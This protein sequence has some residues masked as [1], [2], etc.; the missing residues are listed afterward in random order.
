MSTIGKAILHAPGAR[1]RQWAADWA[2]TARQQVR[3][4]LAIPA[5]IAWDVARIA[6]LV[7]VGVIMHAWNLFGYPRYQGDEGVYMASAWSLLHGNITPY[8][9][10]YGHPPLGWA[11]IALWCQMTGGF[12][13]FGTSV[14]TGRVF[15]VVC[16]AVSAIF[17]YLIALRVTR[18]WH[19]ATIATALFSYSPLSITFQ[20]EVLLDN[21]AIMWMLIAVYLLVISDSRMRY[22]LASAALFG[23]STLTKETMIVL[24][25][26]FAVGVW[27]GVTPFQR[28]YV[29]LVF[30]YATLGIVSIFVLVSLLKNEF[31]PTGTL[32][33][34]QAPHVSMIATFQS[35]VSRGGDQGSFFQQWQ[36][37][38]GSDIVLTLG[39]LI[40]TIANLWLYRT[41][42][43]AQAIALLPTIY[44]LFLAR[45]G[46]TFAYYIIV[47][48]PFFA[49]NIAL[50]ADLAITRLINESRVERPA[51]AAGSYARVPDV[52]ML[53][54]LVTVLMIGVYQAPIN[55]TDLTASAVSPEVEAMQWM[56][57]NAPRSSTVV[58]NHYFYLDLRSTGGMGAPTGASFENVQMYWNVAT[59]KAVLNGVLH[60]NW[61][62]IDYVIEDSDM[63]VDRKNYDMTIINQAIAHSTVAAK[64]QNTLFWVTIYQVR[65]T[66]ANAS[67]ANARTNI[68]T[69]V[70]NSGT[71]HGAA[72]T[73]A[74][75]QMGL[76]PAPIVGA[77]YAA[78]AS[79][80]AQLRVTASMLNLRSGPSLT[81]PVV[82][83]L[84]YGTVVNLV[85]SRHGWVYVTDNTLRGW[86]ARQWTSPLS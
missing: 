7:L 22:L 53:A 6:T 73:S 24:F 64:F 21:I 56:A 44:F 70:S 72:P 39:G 27:R 32:L 43:I 50:L 14:N 61:N 33:G 20:R 13:T 25:P 17:V 60:D 48:L 55:R 9:Y 54:T 1:A 4:Q 8:T 86:V 71:A 40:A 18:H 29:L 45:G 74:H 67:D 69:Q 77:T 2:P 19:T 26:A 36:T 5:S 35:Q 10:T 41:K 57:A 58:A 83:L 16:Y 66:G 59:D 82:S 68:I 42:P 81:S 62:N 3:E 28:R 38:I 31:F 78:R 75:A 84:P 49:L 51:G 85:T 65:H 80:P 34:G 76:T 12:F 46:V 30:S 11:L 52:V 15:M 23:V 63:L 79:T 47:V 37:W